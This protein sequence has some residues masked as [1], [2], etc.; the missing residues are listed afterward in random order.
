V[1]NASL[2]ICALR[3]GW[4][5]AAGVDKHQIGG[6]FVA[7]SASAWLMVTAT[8]HWISAT[9]V[10]IQYYV[11]RHLVGELFSVDGDIGGGTTG[12][13]KIGTAVA[14]SGGP[15]VFAGSIDMLRVLN[16]HVTAEEVEATYLRFAKWQP[17]GYTTIRQLFQPGAPISTEPKS[18][19]QRLF[20]G[21]GNAL[22]YAN[23]Q[24][25]NFRRNALPDRAYGTALERWEGI[26]QESPRPT[27]TTRQRRARVMGHLA[28][29][30]GVTIAGVKKAI[31]T[32]LQA[33]ASQLQIIAYAND[34]IPDGVG[35]SHLN[36]ATGSTA[37]YNGLG[38]IGYSS[39]GTSDFRYQAGTVFGAQPLGPDSVMWPIQ[40]ERANLDAGNRANIIA[41]VV[42]GTFPADAAF[43]VALVDHVNQNA[44]ILELWNNAGTY[45]IAYTEVLAGVAGNPVVLATVTNVPTFLHLYS[46]NPDVTEFSPGAGNRYFRCEWGTSLAAMTQSAKISH[47][48]SFQYAGVQARSVSTA[49]LTLMTATFDNI[50]IRQW[51]GAR[52]FTWTIYRD[53]AIPGVPDFSAA[54]RIATR[55]SHAFTKVGVTANLVAKTDDAN[56]VCD[57]T[58]VGAW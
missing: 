4:Q 1:I 25:D 52:P 48:R 57:Q 7:P 29:R 9:E 13:T 22:G 44:I 58:P 3:W 6:Y 41:R 47:P 17:D 51:Y 31:S 24:V 42:P 2:R 54:R 15:H 45:R 56:S 28:Q 35:W 23:A 53:P 26:T 36:G 5:T 39:Q 8:R 20:K 37:D 27:D 34:Y 38:N 19:V 18:R 32:V 11:G 50:Q 33:D 43:G 12:T 40:S 14:Y 55:L 16:Y 10:E 21:I 46:M 49:S 30:Q